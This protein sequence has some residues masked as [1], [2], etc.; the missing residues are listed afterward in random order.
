M[1]R[2]LFSVFELRVVDH[3]P[4]GGVFEIF[5]GIRFAPGAIAGDHIH[6]FIG[7]GQAITKDFAF[8]VSEVHDQPGGIGRHHAEK[9]GAHSRILEISAAQRVIQSI[10]IRCFH[11]SGDRLVGPFHS[12]LFV[13]FGIGSRRMQQSIRNNIQLI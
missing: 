10:H 9:L 12:F 4:G 2:L 7:D 8:V 6:D 5:S 1:A 11:P 13:G 3:H